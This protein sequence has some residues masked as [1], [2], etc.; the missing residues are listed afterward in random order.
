MEIVAAITDNFVIGHGGDMPWHLPADLAHFKSLTSGHAVVMGR[1]TWESIGEALPDRHNI[2]ISRQEAYEATGAIV[3]HS[4]AEAIQ[5]S[6]STRCFVIGGGEIYATAME[7]A[8]GLHL[9]R[10]HTTLEGDTVFPKF[11]ESKWV[12]EESIAHPADERN[13]YP[14]TFEQWVSVQ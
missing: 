7:E 6:G 11:K 4:L 8:I 12:L 1:R 3:V 2:V 9:T 5:K 10:I 14:M 13:K